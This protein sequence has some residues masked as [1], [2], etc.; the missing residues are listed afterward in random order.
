MT[1]KFPAAQDRLSQWLEHEKSIMGKTVEHRTGALY[2]LFKFRQVHEDQI[3]TL[4]IR[5]QRAKL[6]LAVASP[7]FVRNLK[8]N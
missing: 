1:H 5:A 3:F 8:Y 4:L 2:T 6:Q 7:L